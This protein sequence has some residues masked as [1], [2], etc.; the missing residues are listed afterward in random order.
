MST[1]IKKKRITRGIYYRANKTRLLVISLVFGLLYNLNHLY[2]NDYW[3]TELSVEYVVLITEFIGLGYVMAI[4]I[5]FINTFFKEHRNMAILFLNIFFL[6][7]TIGLWI[8]K[9]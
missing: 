7:I 5:S 4:V 2:W 9:G 1:H 6:V 8:T 3:F